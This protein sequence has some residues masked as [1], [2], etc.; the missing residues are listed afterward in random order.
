MTSSSITSISDTFRVVNAIRT[1]NNKIRIGI[2][3]NRVKTKSEAEQIYDE[4]A[5]F[6][7]RF[8]DVFI[9]S[10][11]F[12]YDNQYVDLSVQERMP[13]VIFKPECNASKCIRE[14]AEC[15][16]GDKELPSFDRSGAI[17]EGDEM[18]KT[19]EPSRSFL[20]ENIS[21]ERRITVRKNIHERLL[22]SYI[23]TSEINANHFR[24][25]AEY[26]KISP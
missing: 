13:V 23:D 19:I 11:G 22:Y 16:L 3:V 2:I 15:I 25:P 18:I 21:N 4:L 6:C 9:H 7:F 20:P 8:Y 5:N 24:G 10:Y 17:L 1:L 26:R 14:I 12:I